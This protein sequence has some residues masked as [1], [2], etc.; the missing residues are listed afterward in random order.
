VGCKNSK[1]LFINGV[2]DSLTQAVPL[3]LEVDSRN[4]LWAHLRMRIV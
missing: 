2:L 3:D 1:R 4:R